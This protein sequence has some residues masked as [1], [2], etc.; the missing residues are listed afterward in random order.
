MNYQ[1]EYGVYLHIGFLGLMVI[2]VSYIG[3]KLV[4]EWRDEEYQDWKQNNDH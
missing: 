3:Y 2:V 1:N 4:R